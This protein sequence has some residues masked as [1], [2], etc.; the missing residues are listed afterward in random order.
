MNRI[1]ES[2]CT[3]GQ[4]MLIEHDAEQTCRRDG[5]RIFYSHDEGTGRCAFRCRSCRQPVN[6]TVPGAEYGE[7]RQPQV[8]GEKTDGDLEQQRSDAARWQW[9]VSDCDGNAQDD[10]VRWLSGIVTDKAAID[11]KIDE[12][13]TASALEALVAN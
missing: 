8:R 9:L 11:A 7:S 13:R 12:L 2:A 3:C 4:K 5:K 6:E 10:F 1:T